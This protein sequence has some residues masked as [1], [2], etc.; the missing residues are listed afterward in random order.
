M[1]Y[2]KGRFKPFLAEGKL[3]PKIPSCNCQDN[4]DICF[5]AFSIIEWLP[6][7]IWNHSPETQ[8]LIW[9]A[10]KNFPPHS[11]KN[12]KKHRHDDQKYL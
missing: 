10:L 12:K 5:Y 2:V 8:I 11:L 7:M 3:H 6:N 4:I 1:R 9:E